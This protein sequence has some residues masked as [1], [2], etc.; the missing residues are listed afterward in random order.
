MLSVYFLHFYSL[1]ISVYLMRL[2]DR[3][4]QPIAEKVNRKAI[5]FLP[6]VIV[7]PLAIAVLLNL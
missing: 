1:L 2:L 3:G 4:D 6:V 5:I 7:I